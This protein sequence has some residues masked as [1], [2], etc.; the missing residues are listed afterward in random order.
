M[1]GYGLINNKLADY[2]W[3]AHVF[4]LNLKRRQWKTGTMSCQLKAGY[5]EIQTF[6]KFLKESG[7]KSLHIQCKPSSIRSIISHNRYTWPRFLLS[8]ALKYWIDFSLHDHVL[9]L[10]NFAGDMLPTD[11]LPFISK[12][13]CHTTKMRFWWLCMK[14]WEI[15][16]NPF[17][18]TMIV[19]LCSL[20]RS[21]SQKH[22]W[23]KFLM[24]KLLLVSFIFICFKT[25]EASK[26]A[27]LRLS[28]LQNKRT[29]I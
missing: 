6:H 25:S 23:L 7:L 29:S 13:N 16:P 26:A 12:V 5:S 2:M 21:A 4:Q 11:S 8:S 3:W 24:P 18:Q 19:G 15:P 14:Q 20:S 22:N 27:I 28:N 1:N 10:R 17:Q 9:T